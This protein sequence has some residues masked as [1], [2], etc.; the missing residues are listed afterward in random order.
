MIL[1]HIILRVKAPNFERPYR[2][3]G[4]VVTKGIA[5]VLAIVAFV[6]TF[7]VR[8]ETV[9]WLG[10]FYAILVAYFALYSRQGTRRRVCCTCKS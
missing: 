10:V 7:V 4:G 3:S 6:S 8:L 5:L 1:S 9:F 2:T